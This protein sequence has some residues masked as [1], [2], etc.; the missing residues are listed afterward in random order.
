MLSIVLQVIVHLRRQLVIQLCLWMIRRIHL[1]LL[2]AMLFRALIQW[3][4][5]GTHC[6]IIKVMLALPR[7]CLYFGAFLLDLHIQRLLSLY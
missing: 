4:S 1:V 7:G 5:L 6:R 2:I 3:F